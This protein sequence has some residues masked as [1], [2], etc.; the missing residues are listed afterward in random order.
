[1]HDNLPADANGFDPFTLE[2]IR[3]AL[4]AIP[5]QIE[6]DIT[7][8]A[9][10]P[11]IYEYKDFAV[12]LVDCDGRMICQGKGGLPIFLANV[13]GLAV[14]DALEVYGRDGIGPG[15][16]I[17]SNHAGTLGQHL[18]NVVMCTP[19]FAGGERP[20]AFM[21]VLVHWIDVGG[22]YVGSSAS[23]DTTEIFQEGI[24][25]RSVKL[26]RR[27][28]KVPEIYRI[29]ECNTRFPGA[30]FGDI[31]AQLSG[32][33]KGAQ[34]FAECVGRYGT[35]AVAA[36]V[37]A[38]WQNSEAA[39]RAAVQAI[40]DGVYRA[41]S[42]LD[43]DGVDLD[44]PIRVEVTVTV[45][46]DGMTVDLSGCSPE[47]RGPFNSGAYGGGITAARTAF[48][49]LTTP[50]EPANDGSFAPLSV[51]LPPGTFLSAGPTAALAR[52]SSPLPT[53]MDT[54]I[55]ALAPAMPDR[56]AAGHHSNMGSHRF[57]GAHPCGGHRFSHLDTAHGGWGASQGRDGAGPFKTLA[58]GDTLDVP[59]EAQEALYPLRVEAYALRP[60]SGGAGEFRG[61]LG[62]DK[63]Y[64]VL[65][66][67]QLTSTFERS[68]CPPWG[69]FGG[70][71]AATAYLEVERG[72][73]GRTRCLKASDIAIA[74]GDRVYIKSG[75][76][77]GFGPPGRRA[78]RRVAEDVRQGY[79]S[80]EAA[81][82][83]YAVVVTEAGDVDEAATARLRSDLAERARCHIP[84]GPAPCG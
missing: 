49:Y 25:F 31:E 6:L 33:L 5:E 27:G 66:P 55:R 28:E 44:R 52:Y 8:T 42:F 29:I 61:G 76:G 34:L 17:I 47:L 53:V 71:D 43:N 26:R 62:I 13:L 59:I 1:M 78:A 75:G 60:D 64:T 51:M 12:G 3:Y 56:I 67:C 73:E 82:R 21:A 14:Q 9:Y 63:A 19:I 79:V 41:S 15:D 50:D 45:A 39:A 37:A 4:Q 11:L 74:A 65:A 70:H 77:G 68:L 58:H 40:P 57:Q 35:D 54:I 69:L 72:G 81:E 23:N 48:K 83:D 22:R 30:L 46:G 10:S 18:N 84:D 16:A 20:L 38:I 7:R 36:A 80:R 2:L 24:Q 32:C